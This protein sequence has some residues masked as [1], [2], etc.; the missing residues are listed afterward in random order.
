MTKRLIGLLLLALVLGGCQG[1]RWEWGAEEPAKSPHAT[2]D[3]PYFPGYRD[4]LTGFPGDPHAPQGWTIGRFVPDDQKT[5]A[6][7]HYTYGR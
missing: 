5:A 2:G 3:D 4:P 1:M 6:F 7:N